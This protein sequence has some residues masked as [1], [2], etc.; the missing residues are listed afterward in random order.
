MLGRVVNKVE[1]NVARISLQRSLFAVCFTKAPDKFRHSVFYSG[2]IQ[3][4]DFAYRALTEM[5]VLC[6]NSGNLSEV[7][8]DTTTPLKVQMSEFLIKLGVRNCR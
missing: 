7:V 6:I 3:R 1:T 8:D 5:L 4:I 2:A